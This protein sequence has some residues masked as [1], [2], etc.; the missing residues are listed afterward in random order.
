MPNHGVKLIKKDNGQ[1]LLR[2]VKERG[3]IS[4]ADLVKETR[5][6][7][8][9]VS[10]LIQELIDA[11]FLRETGKGES[12]GGKPPTILEFLP[13]AAYGIGVDISTE[14]K[15][16]LVLCDLNATILSEKML[17]TGIGWE[18]IFSDIETGI[19]EIL[20]SFPKKKIRGIG[21]AASGIVD[22]KENEILYS[23]HFDYPRRG[24]AARLRKKFALPVFV[25]NVMNSSA[26]FE[27]RNGRFPGARNLLYVTAQRGVGAGVILEDKIFYG[28]HLGAGQIGNL[29]A[30]PREG[31][32]SYPPEEALEEQLGEEAILKRIGAQVTLEEALERYRSGEP[33]ANEVFRRSA[34]M[35]AYPVAA[36]SSFFNPAV[37]VLSG[38]FRDYG[39]KFLG[40]FENVFKRRLLPVFADE[41]SVLLSEFGREIGPLGAAGIVIEK[42][43]NLEMD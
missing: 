39:E 17:A 37:V 28:N 14:R 27:K 26:W 1:R 11:K 19:S 38:R 23:T 6:G 2:L 43:L 33:R 30:F 36:I 12:S 9:T 21:L 20:S 31:V 5:L 16:H 40:D 15:I 32:L 8:A 35:L 4:R 13:D 18:K 7:K 22:P 34:E 3:P 24:L 42:I 25:E 41:T 10:S 29:I